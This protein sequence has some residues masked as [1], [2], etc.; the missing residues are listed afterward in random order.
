MFGIARPSVREAIKVF[1]YLGI[2]ES[3]PG[4]GTFISDRGN[5]P[6]EA[7]T[8][9]ILLGENE[10]VEVIKLREILEEAGLRQLTHKYS[11]DPSSV[12]QTIESL[13][14]EVEK[15]ND[16]MSQD[17]MEARVQADVRLHGIIIGV[18]G[19]SLVTAIYQTLKAFMHE[20]IIYMYKITGGGFH[21]SDW[22]RNYV[23]TIKAGNLDAMIQLLKE[24]TAGMIGRLNAIFKETG[25]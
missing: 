23:E 20:H 10:L 15:F 5:I 16:A 11:E 17:D 12:S 1:Q 7:L 14:G 25:E 18:G 4:R 8:W 2:M 24:H 6:A 22:H 9:S 21:E 19:N 3:I 13:E